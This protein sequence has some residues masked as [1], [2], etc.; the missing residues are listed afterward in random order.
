MPDKPWK[1]HKL[2]S[3][4]LNRPPEQRVRRV[5]GTFLPGLHQWKANASW[6]F[7]PVQNRNAWHH[8][9]LNFASH[10][11]TTAVFL[12]SASFWGNSS[13]SGQWLH[14]DPKN[15]SNRHGKYGSV[16]KRTSFND[17]GKL[18]VRHVP[19]ESHTSSKSWKELPKNTHECNQPHSTCKPFRSG[20]KS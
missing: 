10:V 20:L 7:Q 8:M 3:A 9:T 5:V 17:H 2:C 12:S 15:V 13:A 16:E 4:S 1:R 11:I 19:K 6:W 18:H 14:F